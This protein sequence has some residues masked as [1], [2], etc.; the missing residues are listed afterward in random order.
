MATTT[1]A[2]LRLIEGMRFTATTGSGHDVGLDAGSAS[3][4]TD[5]AATPVELVLTAAAGCMAMDAVSILR[6]MRQHVAGYDIHAEGE[7]AAEHP[8]VLTQIALTHQLHGN[9]LA[10]ANVAR[11]LQLSMTRYCP[12]FAMLHPGV[13]FV[14]RYEVTDDEDGTTT[15][16]VAVRESAATS[17]AS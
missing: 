9:A 12:V 4:G 16:G 15:S 17:G 11:A 2:D 6:K 7:R 10:A 3:G 8:R 5:A 1:R 13:A 14:V